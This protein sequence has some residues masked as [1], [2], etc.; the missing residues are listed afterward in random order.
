ME[1]FLEN[2]HALG[3]PKIETNNNYWAKKIKGLIDKNPE[4]D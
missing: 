4:M 2:I 3:I 1:E